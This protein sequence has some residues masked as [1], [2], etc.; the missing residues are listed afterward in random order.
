MSYFP[1]QPR[2]YVFT[3]TGGSQLENG[4]IW[5]GDANKDPKL[6]PAK[7]AWDQEG[8]YAI[9]FPI[10]TEHGYPIRGEYPNP[11][12]LNLE[13]N[14]QYSV[15]ITEEDGTTVYSDATG[16]AGYFP[17]EAAD[18]ATLGGQLPSYY[19]TDSL[20]V[21]LAGAE[22]ITG[23]KTFTSSINVT[24][25][26]AYLGFSE[27]DTLTSAR[28]SLTGGKIYI[29]AG[30]TGGYEQGSGDLIFCGWGGSVDIGSLE[31]RSGGANQTIWHA[32]NDT[33]L[34]HLAGAETV[35]GAKT[36]N[37]DITLGTGVQISF[38]A[39]NGDKLYLYGNT[40]GIGLSGGN[41][42]N[43]WSPLQYV[44]RSGGTSA[45]T[46][47]QVM[48][49]TSTGNLYVDGQVIINNAQTGD[50]TI[51]FYDVT[52]ATLRSLFWDDS[53]SAWYVEDSGGANRAL[54][55]AGI[56]PSLAAGNGISGTI[57]TTATQ[58]ITVTNGIITAIA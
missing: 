14:Y 38:P 35:T 17:I 28:I 30:D 36:F 46:G 9:E 25:T 12:Y 37:A 15:L 44:W 2:Y 34:M 22:T 10:R 58:T 47:D 18:A 19:A 52:N 43:Y 1:L 23:V 53:A 26:S 39:L 31:V 33:P 56:N 27:T 20:V 29:F 41:T 40:C 57:D 32:G 45:T 8:R 13:D 7:A 21:H 3:D 42:L 49:L 4:Y 48:S 6:F 24:G 50:S 16:L 54:Y 51:Q 5:I 55:H 11:I